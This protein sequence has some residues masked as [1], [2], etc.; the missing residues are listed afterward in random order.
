MRKK[1]K[2][3][4]GSA[5]AL[6]IF[7]ASVPLGYLLT[8]AALASPRSY[9][10]WDANP[11]RLAGGDGASAKPT[12]LQNAANGGGDIVKKT[13]E[14]IPYYRAVTKGNNAATAPCLTAD[15]RSRVFRCRVCR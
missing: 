1:F 5:L 8:T 12:N 15:L 2:A 14:A 10:I 9:V 13:D 7:L 6:A 4:L 3:Y 11:D